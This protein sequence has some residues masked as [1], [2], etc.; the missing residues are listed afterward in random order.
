MD[1]DDKLKT[2][3]VDELPFFHKLHKHEVFISNCFYYGYEYRARAFL[4]EHHYFCD[5]IKPITDLMFLLECT[6]Q[7]ETYIV[8]KYEHQII[9]TKFI[10]NEWSCEFKED[11]TP[12]ISLQH[13]DVTLKI[14]TCNARRV[15]EKLFSQEY[16]INAFLNG[17]CIATICMSVKYITN[18]T[19]R[20]IRKNIS[21][22]FKNRS[23]LFFDYVLNVPPKYIYRRNYDNVVVRAPKFEGDKVTSILTVNMSNTA[24]F[25]HVQDHF[26]AMVLMEA[27]KQNC[28]LLLS[29]FYL[30]KTPVLTAMKSIFF[31]YSELD[32]DLQII[33]VK[34]PS[35]KEDKIMF[36]VLLKQGGVEIAQMEY[37]F[38]LIDI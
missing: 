6:R 36:N 34:A 29:R 23:K 25:D 2:C 10:L 5:H 31:L 38:Q 37:V 35:K 18:N 28:Q 8:H 3:E 30:L 24:Y 9:G 33:S 32:R 27:G 15:K 21:K 17:I 1:L 26:P 20:K 19:Y 22:S 13:R 16:K 14:T 4:P 7:A 11:F 12:T